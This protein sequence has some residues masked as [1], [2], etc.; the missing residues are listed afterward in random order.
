MFSTTLET[1][2]IE[3]TLEADSQ[4]V[5]TDSAIAIASN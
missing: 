1:T 4:T 5:F 3:T 2:V